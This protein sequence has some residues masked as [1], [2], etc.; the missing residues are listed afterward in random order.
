MAKK[1]TT[2]PK[3]GSG[4]ENDK[5]PVNATK[6]DGEPMEEVES[7]KPEESKSEHPAE[8]DTKQME[9]VSKHTEEAPK[10]AE[11][12]PKPVEENAKPADVIS[13]PAED[14]AEPAEDI[15]EPAGNSSGM[16]VDSADDFVVVEGGGQD[17]ELAQEKA[18]EKKTKSNGEDVSAGAQP[19]NDVAIA[20]MKG[21]W[22][23][24]VGC[25]DVR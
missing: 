17:D 25:T 2:E 24:W 16:E 1:D 12:F 9:D 4:S 14:I 19:S 20:E 18:N 8:R 22:H 7:A 11:D 3:K 15:A 21:T 23:N 6:D 10:P 5:S 13:K